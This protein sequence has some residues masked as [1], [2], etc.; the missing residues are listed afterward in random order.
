MKNQIIKKSVL[1][2]FLTLSI[3]SFSSF[4]QP[5]FEDEVEDTP[6]DS[7]ICLLGMAALCLGA[8]SIHFKNNKKAV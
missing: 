8:V 7:N 1:T 2:I 4:A 3:C 6:I 5:G